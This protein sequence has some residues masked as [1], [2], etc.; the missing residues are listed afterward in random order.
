MDA[1]KSNLAIWALVGA[2]LFLALAVWFR[3]TTPAVTDQ[4]SQDEYL[5]RIVEAQER[6][7]DALERIADCVCNGASCDEPR[8]ETSLA[9]EGDPELPTATLVP[10]KTQ[11]APTATKPAPTATQ[12][13]PTSTKP[14]PTATKPAP[15]A[16]QPAPT[17][18]PQPTATVAPPEPTES[19]SWWHHYISEG[20]SKR[21]CEQHFFKNSGP[22]PRSD[23][24]PGPCP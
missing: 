7:A 11:P 24:S 9:S 3:P 18:T 12:P 14:A 15:T 21:R 2:V 13:A 19:G 4:S 17:S 1:K 5:A 20:N 10:T 22:N 6:Q 8:F 16:T 23:W